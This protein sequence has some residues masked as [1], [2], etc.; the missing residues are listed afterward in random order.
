MTGGFSCLYGHVAEIPPSHHL[1]H[2]TGGTGSWLGFGENT[3]GEATWE[4]FEDGDPLPTG[5]GLL[6]MALSGFC[7]GA[8]RA[9]RGKK[10]D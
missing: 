1:Y 8:A 3:G 10:R 2:R 5:T 4:G 6:V 9:W 7:Y